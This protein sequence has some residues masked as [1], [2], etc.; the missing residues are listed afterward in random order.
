MYWMQAGYDDN[1]KK[2]YRDYDGFT[3][4]DPDHDKTAKL[5][6]QFTAN[7]QAK[8][9]ACQLAKKLAPKREVPKGFVTTSVPAEQAAASAKLASMGWRQ[10]R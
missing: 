2:N 6:Q 8:S 1:I 7:Y 4:Y 3:V 9:R 5:L 10:F